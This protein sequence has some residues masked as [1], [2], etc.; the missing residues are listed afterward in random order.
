MNR[1]GGSVVWIRL[2]LI[3]ITAFPYALRNIIVRHFVEYTIWGQDYK[4]MLFRNLEFSDLW[5][6]FD[7]V[8]VSTSPSKLCFGISEC[9]WNGKS[10]RKNPDRPN[11]ELKLLALSTVL[12]SIFARTLLLWCIFRWLG[13]CC[14][15]D[16]PTT[17]YNSVILIDVWRLVISTQWLTTVTPVEWKNC[18]AVTNVD[19][20]A[21]LS[22]NQDDD[23]AW[24]RPIHESWIPL[25]IFSLAHLKEG[26]L[27]FN[28]SLNN[29]LLRVL[30]KALLLDNKVM[31]LVPEE[32]CTC[33]ASMPVIYSEK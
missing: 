6:C 31:K 29:G 19:T 4:I 9:F 1:L 7:N 26:L 16:L 8:D 28:K 11:D 32:L 12:R 17:F 10:A 33:M 14:L 3:Y 2:P 25:I 21:H 30:W 18:P 13:S 23:C 24:P 15:V 5:F 22:N 27:C 20:I